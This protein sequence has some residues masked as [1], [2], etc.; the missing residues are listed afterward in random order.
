MPRTSILAHLISS[1]VTKKKYF[2][3]LATVVNVIKLFFFIADDEYKKLPYGDPLEQALA[4]RQDKKSSPSIIL[5][6]IISSS[7]MKKKCFK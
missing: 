1:S 5:A 3:M 4:F 7:A 2:K 6:L